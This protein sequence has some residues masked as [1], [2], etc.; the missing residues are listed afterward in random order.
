[1]TPPQFALHDYSLLELAP[2]FDFSTRKLY[3][4][5]NT[6]PEFDY[7]SGKCSACADPGPVTNLQLLLSANL[8]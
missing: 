3:S 4:R 1:M 7:N 8:R 6:S 2:M 5:G